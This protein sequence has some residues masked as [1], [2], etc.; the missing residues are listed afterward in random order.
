MDEVRL[1]LDAADPGERAAFAVRKLPEVLERIQVLQLAVQVLQHL[2]VCTH[3]DAV[4]CG[5]WM[6][7][8]LEPRRP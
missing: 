2:P 6:R 1:I 7:S 5:A 8:V 3:H 4:S